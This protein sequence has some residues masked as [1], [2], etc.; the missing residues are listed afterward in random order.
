MSQVGWGNVEG[1][2]DKVKQGVVTP[3]GIV[4]RSVTVVNA[5]CQ[6]TR[7]ILPKGQWSSCLSGKSKP[8]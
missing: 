7:L 5:K 8:H 1:G 4:L 2:F 3:I 6:Q